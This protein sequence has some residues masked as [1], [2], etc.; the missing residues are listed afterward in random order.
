MES[1]AQVPNIEPPQENV[2]EIGV[3][4][5]LPKLINSRTIGIFMIVGGG[6]LVFS[7]LYNFWISNQVTLSEVPIID[8]GQEKIVTEKTAA[9]WNVYEN[10]DDNFKI[11]YPVDWDYWLK[12]VDDMDTTTISFF[13]KTEDEPSLYKV[14]IT[15]HP[16][17]E[18]LRA[19]RTDTLSETNI[20]TIKPNKVIQFK[21]I[22]EY[23]EDL[24]LEIEQVYYEIFGEM[25]GS[26]TTISMPVK[27]TE[28]RPTG[29]SGQLCADTE[30]NTTCEYLEIYGCYK[31][32]VCERQKNDECGWTVTP[33]LKA[34]LRQKAGAE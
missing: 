21:L 2:D 14:E 25:L 23:E 30:V 29:C 17:E 27:K 26:F 1:E 19:M 16:L 7:I 15:V 9:D 12:D 10:F 22:T 18:G 34:C 6:A 13:E 3:G 8:A 11:N 5:F 28:C 31:T 32:A 33:E 20:Y 24:T 4:S